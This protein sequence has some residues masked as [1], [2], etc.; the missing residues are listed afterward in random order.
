ML[1]HYRTFLSFRRAHPVFA[2]GAIE[3]LDVGEDVLAFTRTHGN[4]K[5]FCA[6]N[7]GAGDATVAF[8][9]DLEL[10]AV[11]GHGFTS[12]ARNGSIAL[13]AYGAWFGRC[14]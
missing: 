2:K 5:L 10:S 1:E 6:F 7:L 11:E 14:A 4:E 12:T 3:F 8:G 9:S 13:G